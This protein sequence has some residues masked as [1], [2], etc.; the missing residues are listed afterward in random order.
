MRS[1]GSES[2]LVHSVA[3]PEPDDHLLIQKESLI[4]FVGGD[5]FFVRSPRADNTTSTPTLI[6]VPG[7]EEIVAISAGAHHSLLLTSRGWIFSFGDNTFGQLGLGDTYDREIPTLIIEP[8]LGKLI[9]M[10]AGDHHS[11]LLNNQ[12]QV[13]AFGLNDFGQLGLGD[14]RDRH[15][16]YII[17]EEVGRVVAI[18]ARM[19]HSLLLNDQGQIFSFGSNDFGLLGLGDEIDRN[20]PTLI[21]EFIPS[22]EFDNEIGSIVAISAGE[23]HCFFLDSLGQVFTTGRNNYGQL[24]LPDGEDSHYPISIDIFQP[25][26][27]TIKSVSAGGD[28]SLILDSYDQVLSF[29]ENSF[30]QLGQGDEE[31]REVPT[32]IEYPAI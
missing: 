9:A 5:S 13:F 15:T 23:Q 8:G 27:R 10:A 30:G 3:L 7:Q 28:H 12:G 17:E 26:L 16:P 25:E 18:S 14:K 22:I 1:V 2:C 19:N 6:E 32:L 20:T 21:E 24:G 29:G 4:Q 31:E 11:L